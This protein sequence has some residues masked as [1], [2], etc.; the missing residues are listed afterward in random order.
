EARALAEAHYARA[1]RRFVVGQGLAEGDARLKVGAEVELKGVGPLFEG[2]YY[3]T[4][5]R[6]TFDQAEGYRTAFTAERPALGRAA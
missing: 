2:K 1:A 4:R 3:L 5:A 6:H